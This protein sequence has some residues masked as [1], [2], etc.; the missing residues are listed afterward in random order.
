MGPKM[1]S[2]ITGFLINELDVPA[3]YFDAPD[4]LE[5]VIFT[6]GLVDSFGVLRLI[7]FLEEKFNITIDTNEHEINEFDSLSKINN[8]LVQKGVKRI[9]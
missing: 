2:A 9:E 4:C 5:R 3:G 8:L 1:N 6:S 7:A